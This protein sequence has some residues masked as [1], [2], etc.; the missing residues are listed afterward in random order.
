MIRRSTIADLLAGAPSDRPVT[1]MG[2]VRTA[3]RSKNVAFAEITDGSPAGPLQAVF[4]RSV[5]TDEELAGLTTGAC[6]SVTGRLTPSPGGEQE[7]ELRSDSLEVLG[8][9]PDDYPLQKK[10]HSLQFLRRMPHLRPRTNTVGAALRMSHHLS[11]AIHR[12]FDSEGFYYVHAPVITS[13]DAEGAGEAFT[14]TTLE[15]GPGEEGWEGDY[16]GRRA[17]LTVSAQLEAEPLALALGKVYTFGPTF[18][19]DP[20]DT[21]LHSA[22]FWM[23]EP[24]MAFHD[25]EDCM[26]LA[27]RMLASVA[28]AVRERCPS[29]LA[30][31]RRFYA[32]DLDDRLAM[33]ERGGFRRISYESVLGLLAGEEERFESVPSWGDDLMTEHERYLTEERFGGP[34]FVT[35]FPTTLKPFY[36][37]LGDDGRTVAGADLLLPCVGEAVGASQR[38]ERLGLL[39]ERARQRG[40]DV[41]RYEWYFDL[42]RWGSAPHSG[43]GLGFERLLLFLS[44]MENIRDVVPFPRTKGHLY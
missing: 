32:E 13:S 37:R 43:F 24:E 18:R 19:A 30:F 44:G 9:A 29:E 42:R 31:F 26:G 16:F 20:S 40:V 2:W 8:P 11:M 27:E 41:S 23:V 3:R 12:F 10:R 15:D 28:S 14:V 38:E 25:L 22:E 36:M 17:Y 35:D 7:L 21:R 33:L 1:V 6:V 5:F 4:D 34:V 39:E